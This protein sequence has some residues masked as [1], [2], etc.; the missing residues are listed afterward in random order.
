MCFIRHI[1]KTFFHSS[2]WSY[3][4]MKDLRE[5]LEIF[6]NKRKLCQLKNETILNFR[7]KDIKREN[8][9]IV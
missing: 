8:S 6:M 3:R 1:R 4:I 9:I 2:T 5:Y 7:K